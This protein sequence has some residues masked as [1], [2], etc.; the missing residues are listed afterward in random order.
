MILTAMQAP[1]ALANLSTHLT[2]TLRSASGRTY[3]ALCYTSSNNDCAITEQHLPD[4]LTLAFASAGAR[5]EF[6]GT[7]LRGGAPAGFALESTTR[8]ESIGEMQ[9]GAWVVH[10]AKASVVRFAD[11]ARVSLSH[12]RVSYAHCA[13]TTP[14]GLSY[15][16]SGL[17]GYSARIGWIRAYA[18]DVYPPR[19]RFSRFR[20]E[21]LAHCGSTLLLYSGVYA[22]FAPGAQTR[23]PARTRQPD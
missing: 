8:T 6:V 21:L 5:D 23:H 12:N 10:A 4:A 15:T 7:L 11:L 1:H 22:I 19:T 13:Y 3:D 17:T 16:E 2:T 14:W 20:L 18:H 9:S